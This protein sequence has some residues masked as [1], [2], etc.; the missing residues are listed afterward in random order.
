MAW[1]F[2]TFMGGDWNMNNVV[3]WSPRYDGYKRLLATSFH[4]TFFC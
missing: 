2:V 3:P 4:W 1:S